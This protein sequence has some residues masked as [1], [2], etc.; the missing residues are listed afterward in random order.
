[1]LEKII[2]AI[3]ITCSL[4]WSVQIKPQQRVVTMGINSHWE[5]VLV[6]STVEAHASQA[7]VFAIG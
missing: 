3:A 5:A 2:L 7:K 4:S 6:Q 1:M